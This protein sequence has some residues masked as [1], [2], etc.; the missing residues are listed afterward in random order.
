MEFQVK[1]EEVE[2]VEI[3][4]KENDDDGPAENGLA[5][6]S[7]DKDDEDLSK[8]T[9]KF[10]QGQYVWTEKRTFDMIR[11][12]KEYREQ[13]TVNPG[14]KKLM[15]EHI[16]AAMRELG[17][18][19]CTSSHVQNKYKTLT[20]QY[21]VVCDHNAIPGNHQR[22]FP[23]FEA[24]SEVYEYSPPKHLG[25]DD[26]D[27]D[28][29]SSTNQKLTSLLVNINRDKKGQEAKKLEKLEVMHRE[30]ME[31]FS[32]FLK[33]VNK[34]PNDSPASSRCRKRLAS[35]RKRSAQPSDEELSCD[36]SDGDNE[37][38]GDPER[39]A[40]PK[41]S[42]QKGSAS[43]KVWKTMTQSTSELTSL[44]TKLNEERKARDEMKMSRLEKMHDEKMKMFSAFL[45]VIKKLKK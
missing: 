27:F 42:S 34:K 36:D 45:D 21:R 8:Y 43:N 44:I 11:L 41:K 7:G 15:W 40:S 23:F 37:S 28:D 20:R 2:A 18:E 19:K 35:T 24:M 5:S 9:L 14:N 13:N 29:E 38:S 30:K 17:Y 16:A 3:A 6:N 33:T 10:C 22:A 25:A 31:M 12:Y 4:D 39:V 26:V 32:S 1:T